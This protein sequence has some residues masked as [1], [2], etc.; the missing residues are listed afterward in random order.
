[1]AR[2]WPLFIEQGLVDVIDWPFATGGWAEFVAV[3]RRAF[4]KA[5]ELMAGRVKW[6]AFID[7]DE[8]LFPVQED[9]LRKTLADYEEF[10]GVTVNRR[11]FGTAGTQGLP[12]DS[13]MIETLRQTCDTIAGARLS[14]ALRQSS[15][16]SMRTALCRDRA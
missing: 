3:R 8:F 2:F 9:C 16:S 5:L 11:F 15:G 12:P 14:S 13:L 7:T 10:A 1:M 6:V 4:E